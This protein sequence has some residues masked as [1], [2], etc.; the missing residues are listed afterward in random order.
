MESP[1]EKQSARR[2]Q[3]TRLRAMHLP[4]DI[5]QPREVEWLG[6]LEQRL[7]AVEAWRGTSSRSRSTN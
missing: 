1:N 2:A 6:E 5:L 4:A 3:V 7:A